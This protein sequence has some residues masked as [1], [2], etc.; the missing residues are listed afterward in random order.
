M[1]NAT[2][3]NSNEAIYIVWP[4]TLVIPDVIIL[5]GLPICYLTG[6]R[7]QEQILKRTGDWLYEH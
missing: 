2:F 6:N 4:V 7:E 1:T 3:S 5:L